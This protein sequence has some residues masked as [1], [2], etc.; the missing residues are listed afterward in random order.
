MEG[1]ISNKTIVRCFTNSV[2]DDVKKL[3]WTFPFQLCKSFYQ[4]PQYDF[5]IWQSISICYNGDRLK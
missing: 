1:G 4:F 2:N 3:Y 5:R